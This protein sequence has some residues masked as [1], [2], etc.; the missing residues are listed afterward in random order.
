MRWRPWRK[1][2]GHL[3]ID[4]LHLSFNYSY[5]ANQLT[6]LGIISLFH[7]GK[8]LKADDLDNWR[9]LSLTNGD[10]KIVAKAL[11]IRLDTVM[12]KIIGEQQV[13]FMKGRDISLVHRRIND[14]L[15]LQKKRRKRGMIVALDFKQAF[16]AVNLNCILKT[17]EVFGF[18]ESFIRWISTLNADRL[19]SCEEWRPHFRPIPYE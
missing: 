17:L 4:H 13:G 1:S 3:Q 8:E 9:P 2:G 18:G 6:R 16:D 14:I 15:E 5:Q 19:A 12:E 7:K 10:Y 11:S